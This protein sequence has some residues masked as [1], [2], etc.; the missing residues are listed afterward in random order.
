M[1]LCCTKTRTE[2]KMAKKKIG[3]RVSTFLPIILPFLATQHWLHGLLFIMLGGTAS[4]LMSMSTDAMLPFQ[5]VMIVLTLAAVLWSVYQLFKDG[6]QHKGM[7]VMTAISS[8]IGIGYVIVTFVT[9]G[10]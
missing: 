7:I 2:Q 3:K 8:L 6:V 4:E 1:K 5:R 10:W 9:T